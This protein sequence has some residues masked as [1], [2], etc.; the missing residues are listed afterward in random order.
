MTARDFIDFIIGMTPAEVVSYLDGRPRLASDDDR[1]SLWKG[2]ADYFETRARTLAYAG[3]N[4][5]LTLELATL[6]INLHQRLAKE[7]HSEYWRDSHLDSEM[8]VCCGMIS[9]L[10]PLAGHP[11]LDPGLLE[12]LFLASANFALQSFP[13]CQTRRAALRDADYTTFI[14]LRER[15]SMLRSL[16]ADGV[17]PRNEELRAWE[18]ALFGQKPEPTRGRGE[19]S[20]AK[21][22][23]SESRLAEFNRGAAPVLC[24][25]CSGELRSWEPTLTQQTCSSCGLEIRL[26]A[27]AG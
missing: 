4:I 5:S 14:R 11:V 19:H 17:F 10:S 8:S 3:E 6:S 15:M 25:H 16:I 13:Q 22:I 23:V 21:P 18:E 26:R 1:Q 9:Y 7:A 12:E 24:P 20:L 27:S 2:I